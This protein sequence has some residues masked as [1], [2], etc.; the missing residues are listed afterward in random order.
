M[1]RGR[2]SSTCSTRRASRSP[3]T[4]RPHEAGIESR[5]RVREPGFRVLRGRGHLEHPAEDPAGTA[6]GKKEI[7]CQASYQICNAQSCSFPGRWTLPD[8]APTDD[9][10]DRTA[11]SGPARSKHEVQRPQ[12]LTGRPAEEGQLG[13][14]FGP[15]A[16][17]SRRSVDPVEAHPGQDVTYKVKVALD[18]G[19][20]IY[21]VARGQDDRRRVRSPPRSTSSTPPASRSQGTGSP[22]VS[23][24]PGPSQRSTTSSSSSSRTRSPG[25]SP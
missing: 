1:A 10:G 2:R 24:K 6:P 4:G 8:A 19:L 15:R 14:E 23:R 11:G 16:S 12:L 18:P 17:R 13:S 9:P 7:R 20:H 5:A 22:T 3:A 25:A 21:A